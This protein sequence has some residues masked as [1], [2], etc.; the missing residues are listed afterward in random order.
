VYPPDAGRVLLGERDIAGLPGFRVAR[1]GVARTFQTA[2]LAPELSALDNVAVA[3][4][5]VRLGIGSALFGGRRDRAAVRGEAMGLLALMGAGDYAAALAGSLPPGVARLVEIAR[6]LAVD[7]GFLLLD[8][9]AAGLNEAEQAALVV[10]LRGIAAE[11]VGLLVIEHNMPFLAGLVDRMV[12]L[13]QG[14]VIAAGTPEAVQADPRVIA[15][16]LG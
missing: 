6:A 5:A 9:P 2:A 13:D 3:R 14:R 4:G 15:A 11:G 10:R 1:L 16:Y 7:P 12:C 8:E